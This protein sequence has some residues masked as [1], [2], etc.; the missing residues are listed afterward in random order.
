MKC[1]K[2]VSVSQARIYQFKNLKEKLYK[3]KV[4]IYFNQV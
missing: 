3:C 4:D 2:I 1:L